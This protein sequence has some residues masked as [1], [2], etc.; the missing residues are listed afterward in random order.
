MLKHAD[1]WNAPETESFTHV[2]HTLD[3]F[4]VGFP[5]TT[6]NT[7]GAHAE[8]TIQG[9]SVEILAVRG[10]T[11][12]QNLK[13]ADRHVS[14][15][16]RQLII[17]SRDA[18]NALLSSRDGTIFRRKPAGNPSGVKFNDPGH[19]RFYIGFQELLTDFMGANDPAELEGGI[20]ARLAN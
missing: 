9:K 2:V 20:C 19:N 8:A 7:R 18:H 3:I 17:V 4:R 1:E 5:G 6:S 13:H 14:S 16:R 10:P 15:P 11:H 12:D